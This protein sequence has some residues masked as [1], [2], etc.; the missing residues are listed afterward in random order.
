MILSP[1]E[2]DELLQQEGMSSWTSVYAYIAY[3]QTLLHSNAVV[4]LQ[5]N[6]NASRKFA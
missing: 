1:E 4:P 3:E 5:R 6:Y 2:Q